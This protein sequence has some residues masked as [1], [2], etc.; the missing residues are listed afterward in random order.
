MHRLAP[1]LC[2]LLALALSACDALE[3]RSESESCGDSCQKTG[4]KLGLKDRK[5]HAYAEKTFTSDGE[6]YTLI[7]VE[8]GD[9]EECDLFDDCS[10]STYCGFRVG[11]DDFPLEVS[12]VSDEDQLFDPEAYCEDGDLESCELPGAR[13]PIME[14]EDF[15]TWVYETDPEDEILVDCFADYW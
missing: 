6:D 8:Y 9:T 1:A 13:L 14:D 15:E 3:G 5:V 2:A 12:W 11:G 4:E 7:R 10:Y